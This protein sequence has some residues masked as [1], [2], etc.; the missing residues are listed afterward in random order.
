V[1][2]GDPEGLAD[3]GRIERFRLEQPEQPKLQFGP[4][5]SAIERLVE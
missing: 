3:R 5:S 4:D 1:R 2:L